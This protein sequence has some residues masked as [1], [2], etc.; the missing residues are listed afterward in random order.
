VL[1]QVDVYILNCERA[2]ESEAKVKYGR[3]LGLIDFDQW[4]TDIQVAYCERLRVER[5]D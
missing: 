1:W 5:F 3:D 2:V 4:S